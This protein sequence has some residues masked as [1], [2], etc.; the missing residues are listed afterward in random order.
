V[1]VA[2]TIQPPTEVPPSAPQNLAAADAGD[3][4]ASLRWQDT[5]DN[6][7]TFDIERNP[8]FPGGQ[9]KVNAN[10]ATFVDAD[11]PAG[12]VQYRVRASNNAGA[13]SFTPWADV[14]I[15]ES[16]PA[17]PNSFAA[18]DAGNN[19]DV[20][21][22]WGDASDNEAGFRIERQKQASGV[23]GTTSALNASAN[24]TSLVDQPGPGPVRYRIASTNTAGV[25]AFSAWVNVT[26]PNPPTDPGA[27]IPAAPTAAAANDN[28]S[29][30]GLVWTDASNNET[31]FEI[32]RNPAF[33]SGVTVGANVSGYLDNSGPGTFAY[34]VRSFNGAGSSTWSNWANVI[35]AQPL[36][37]GVTGLM[38]SDAG[39]QRDVTVRWTDNQSDE[40]GF[41]VERQTFAGS[42]WGN[43]TTRTVSP[44]TSSLLD[45]PGLGQHRYRVQSYNASGDGA[46]TNYETITVTAG[47]TPIVKS[48]DTREIYV[49]SSQ[50]NDANDGL[51]PATAVKTLAKG[52]T[53]LRSGFPDH[54][55][56]RRGDTWTREVLG[57]TVGNWQKSGRSG[58]EPLVIHS[59]NDAD[60]NRP[61]IVTHGVNWACLM[62]N[63]GGVNNVHMIGLD[64]NS[65]GGELPGGGIRIYGQATNILF[66]DLH[67]GSFS[68][69]F[70]FEKEQSITN[71]RIRRS[72]V[73]DAYSKSGSA[74]S[75]GIYAYGVDGLLI[76]DC[77]FDHNGWRSDGLYAGA[78]S[79]IYNHN[80]YFVTNST[81]VNVRNTISSRASATGMQ[82]RGRFSNAYNVLSLNNPLGL[83][84]G[85]EM[86][87]WPGEA[88]SGSISYSVV[89]GSNDIGLPNGPSQPRGMGV[90]WGRAKGARVNNNIV[91]HNTQTLG[92]EGGLFTDG[93]YGESAT[94]EDNI[95]YNWKGR[96]TTPASAM[97][98]RRQL[99]PGEVLRRNTFIQPN[100]GTI[101][102]IAQANTGGS[103]S[104][105]R[106]FSTSNPDTQWFKH[107]GQG[108]FNF[109]SWVQ[110]SGETG[111]QNTNTTFPDP[112]RSVATYMTS[113]GKTPT[114]EAFLA[115]A[116]KQSKTNWRTEFTAGAVN[117]HIRQGFGMS[118]PSTS[119]N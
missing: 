118:E 47:W 10:L 63:G 86:G 100:G 106:Y 34:R 115:E 51:T 88:W 114:L 75:Q 31:G 98:L 32:E 70:V 117:K 93:T 24:T 39:N 112:N 108:W 56:L 12:T 81:N 119:S 18:I 60:P 73:V 20:R 38:L 14:L 104:N 16:I 71:V 116:R 53:L 41:R 65:G 90:T 77:V 13:S 40:Q 64:L 42:A 19:R 92:A 2:G 52:Y 27:T 72:V 21:L 94:V 110:R 89:L 49:S 5:S 6:E 61:K 91:A 1:T 45:A 111:G 68:T 15:A 29:K 67:I 83:S 25:S 9:V 48:A 43:T 37:T 59:Y 26:V 11:A 113:L 8:A 109:A 23:W 50:G 69:N 17:A 7:Q 46:W 107:A 76:E 87:Q 62:M 57:P 97:L 30:V 103:F 101:A 66:E 4:S 78:Y 102:D 58:T 3:R 82:L 80:M 99:L 54:L 22:N 74:H 28:G 55:R 96:G 85:H 35:V 84:G 95:V 36:P 105:N 79:T 33:T 44:N